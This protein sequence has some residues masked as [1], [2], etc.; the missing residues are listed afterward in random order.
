[1]D[2]VHSARMSIKEVLGCVET[3]NACF[4]DAVLT[5]ELVSFGAVLGVAIGY[6]VSAVSAPDD[7]YLPQL[8]MWKFFLVPLYLTV[9]GF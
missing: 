2:K 3:L 8:V 4:R 1:L 7:E 9:T 5:P 6:D